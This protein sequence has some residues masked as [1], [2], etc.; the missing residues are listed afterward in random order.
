VVIQNVD[1]MTKIKLSDIVKKGAK[2]KARKINFNNP[3]V[4]KMLA[5]VLEEKKKCQERS[6]VDWKK[7]N[8]TVIDI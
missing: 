6:K 3:E 7:L 2:L 8:D 1:N 4:Q 5:A